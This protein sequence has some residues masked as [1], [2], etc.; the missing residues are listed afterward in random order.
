M[1]WLVKAVSYLAGTTI[2][3]LV[4]VRL[5]E[6]IP[7]AGGIDNDEHLYRRLTGQSKRDLPPIKHSRMQEIAHYLAQTNGFAQWLLN[8]TRDFLC[9]EG[10]TIT[11]VD[12]KI[13]EVLDTFWQDPIN[14]MDLSWPEMVRELGLFGEQCWPVFVS[15]TTGLVRLA[16]VDPS[17]IREV[18]MDPDNAR[19]PIGVILRD[20]ADQ[21]GKRLRILKGGEDAELF[22]PA[23]QRI[24]AQELTDGDCLYYAINKASSSE[25]RGISDLFALADW[26][27]GYEQL[28][29]NGLER[30]GFLNAFCWDITLEGMDQAGINEW[31]RH[32]PPPK[33][34]SVFPHNEKVTLQAVTPDLKGEDY[35]K[36]ARLVR[37]QI[38]GAAGY[39][40]HWYGGGGDVN[41]ATAAEMSTPT[42]KGLQARQRF[43]KYILT[44]ILTL[45]VREAQARQPNYLGGADS[46]FTIEFPRINTGDLQRAA[47]ALKDV[48]A[49]ALVAEG[50][51]WITKEQAAQLFAAVSMLVGVELAPME[52]PA[53]DPNVTSEYEDV[54]E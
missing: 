52:T 22:A 45:Q 5:R 36:H 44:E 42:L 10:I 20:S 51:Q 30:T 50:N 26:L 35:E 24:R 8:T 40:E 27:D 15:E 14:R 28:I 37:N 34:G 6:A 32:N 4:Q 47:L 21:P 23:A 9:G 25:T 17:A 39:P 31:K 3:Q 33:P 13:Q 19:E 29:W 48:A 46:T 38:L 18:V 49:A 53:A 2:D 41:R 1:G 12:P 54:L 16:S 7:V 11:A 43:V